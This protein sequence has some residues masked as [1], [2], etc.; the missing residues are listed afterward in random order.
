MPDRHGRPSPFPNSHARWAACSRP[1]F[2]EERDDIKIGDGVGDM[3][4]S[5]RD[6]DAIAFADVEE[7]F[8]SVIALRHDDRI[9]VGEKI[10]LV[11]LGV[12]MIAAYLALIHELEIELHDGRIGE[13][14][15]YPAA[16]VADGIEVARGVYLPDL[17]TG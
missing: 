15:E 10:V 16:A 14:G 9:A 2:R 6:V 5:L 4:D 1:I 13:E 8:F 7:L 3:R 17:H 12:V 11:E